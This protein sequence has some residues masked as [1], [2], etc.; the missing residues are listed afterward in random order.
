MLRKLVLAVS[1]IAL[2]ASVFRPPHV[3]AHEQMITV[4][5]GRDG[6]DHKASYSI[7][8]EEGHPVTVTFT[9]ADSDMADDNPHTIR[10]EGP[11][12]AGLPDVTISRENPT[13]TLSFVPSRT[14][15]LWIVCIVP[16]IGMENLAG[17]QIRVQRPRATG[18]ATSVSLA[19]TP[20][21]DGDLLARAVL[22]DARGQPMADRTITFILTTQ[23]GGELVLDTPT[24]ME[25]GS[26]VVRIPATGANAMRITAYFEGGDG[27]AYSESQAD[28]TLSAGQMEHP[29]GQL[30]ARTAPPVLALA[31]IVVLGG[32]WATYGFVVYQVALIRREPPV[33]LTDKP[34]LRPK[35]MFTG[36]EGKGESGHEGHDQS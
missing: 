33:S 26:A 22:T 4:S 24:T 28:A 9:Y 17:G 10:L 6:F 23:F 19:L 30:S 25:D 16:C 31:L 15:L 11:G 12:T 2:L 36:Q 32:V 20:R 27:L 3:L 7:A 35:M 13:A 1:A 21:D 8:V 14:G 5:V 18:A 34:G 29:L